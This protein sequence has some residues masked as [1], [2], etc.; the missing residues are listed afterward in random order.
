[1]CYQ[2]IRNIIRINE[3]LCTGCG[4]CTG[5][6]PNGAIIVSGL[7]AKLIR[8]EYCNG[9]GDCV[10]AC[11]CKAI[12]MEKL[13]VAPFNQAAAQQ[14]LAERISGDNP[15]VVNW[16]IKLRQV[17]VSAPYFNGCDLV[18]AADCT[19]FTHG[20]FR[21]FTT[22]RTVL[23]A[24]TKLDN[25]DYSEQLAKILTRN[26]VRSIH[27][28]RMDVPCC[29]GFVVMVR[30]ALE[31]SGKNIPMVVTVISIKGKVNQ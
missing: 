2:M 23:I 1:M 11:P 20:D 16:P 26:N 30:K 12:T 7:K 10:P 13:D 17:P 27:V 24:C 3:S 5:S 19:A 15:A 9:C 18:I 14:R 4:L 8:E 21:R 31:M 22:G 29:G 28:I 25:Y 6:C